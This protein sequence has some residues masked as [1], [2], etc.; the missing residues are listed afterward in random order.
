MA[1]IRHTPRPCPT[2]M[3]KA[4]RADRWSRLLRDAPRE[5]LVSRT[6]CGAP[7]PTYMA[8]ITSLA[9]PN[10][11]AVSHLPHGCVAPATIIVRGRLRTRKHP[12]ISRLRPFSGFIALD[13]FA[14]AGRSLSCGFWKL[15]VSFRAPRKH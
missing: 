14:I 2:P 4:A 9:V 6:T 10:V 1:Q 8:K 13:P 7:A 5:R 11:S 12:R 3:R 15:L